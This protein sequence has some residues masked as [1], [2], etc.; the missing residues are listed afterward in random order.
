MA[1]GP[2]GHRTCADPLPNFAHTQN[3]FGAPGLPQSNPNV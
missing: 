3:R 1:A 2:Y